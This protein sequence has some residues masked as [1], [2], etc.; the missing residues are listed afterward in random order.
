MRKILLLFTFAILLVSLV[1]A[2][3][4]MTQ[5]PEDAYSLGDTVLL[6][7]KIKTVTG[8][9]DFFTLELL[10]NG[11]QTQVHQEYILLSAGEEKAIIT[12]IPLIKSFTGQS[13]NECSIKAVLGDEYLVT[14]S[15]EI[16]SS[17]TIEIREGDTEFEP[18]QDII[19]Q[20]DSIKTSGDFANGFIDLTLENNGL[21]SPIQISETVQN[22]F[23]SVNF[24]P[25]GT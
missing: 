1:S 6:P 5:Q 16:S 17:I 3:I 10:C 19:I 25:E 2:D 14:E 20:G 4:V 11:K 22:G 23:F 24:S 13:T 7:I 12:T 9:N 18:E 8:I 15:F 21:S